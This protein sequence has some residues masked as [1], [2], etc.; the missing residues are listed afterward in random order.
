M[1]REE[2]QFTGVFCSQQLLVQNQ[3]PVFGSEGL[4]SSLL[5]LNLPLQQ[6]HFSHSLTLVCPSSQGKDCQE[7]SPIKDGNRVLNVKDES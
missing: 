3:D 5:I 7:C 4:A 6:T 2:Q 1:V